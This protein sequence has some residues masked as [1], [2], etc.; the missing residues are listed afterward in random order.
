MNKEQKL[1]IR[2]ATKILVQLRK[3]ATAEA[4]RAADRLNSRVA[5]MIEDAATR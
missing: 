5:K 4:H 1:I 2:D 3:L